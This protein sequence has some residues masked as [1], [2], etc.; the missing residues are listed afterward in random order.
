MPE[1]PYTFDRASAEAIAQTVRNDRARAKNA[2]AKPWLNKESCPGQQVFFGRTTTNSEF[3]TYPEY[4]AGEEQENDTFV[5]AIE[6]AIHDE[7]VP[8]A[9]V[10][11]R[12]RGDDQVAKNFFGYWVEAGTLVI[13][14]KVPTPKGPRWWFIPAPERLAMLYDVEEDDCAL[15]KRNRYHYLFGAKYPSAWELFAQFTEVQYLNH[16]WLDTENGACRLQVVPGSACVLNP[17]AGAAYTA[18]EF[19]QQAVLTDVWEETD[20]LYG[21]TI[22]ITTPCK[23]YTA[24]EKLVDIGPC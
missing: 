24:S 19:Q 12:A 14:F 2:P 1:R 21:S 22:V 6:Y 18:I 16:A 10:D 5:V 23:G 3:P 9:E 17:S 7:S 15:K 20:G 8:Q 13:L 4:T 11:L